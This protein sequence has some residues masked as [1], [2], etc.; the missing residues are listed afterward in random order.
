MKTI[1]DVVVD[2]LLYFIGKQNLTQY[3]LAQLSGLSFSTVK[4]ILQKKTNGVSL[5]S[6][7][8]LADGLGITPSEFINTDAFLAENLDI[9]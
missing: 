3:K 4:T 9:K 5:R 6:I 7:I 2:R 1:N 8:L